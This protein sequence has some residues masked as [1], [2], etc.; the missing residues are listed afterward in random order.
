MA[1][2]QQDSVDFACEAWAYQWVGLFGRDPRKASE[3]LGRLGST[4]GLVRVMQDGAGSSTAVGQQFP[5]GFLG[6]GLLVNCVL[7]HMP[8][9]EREM[10]WRHYVDRWYVVRGMLDAQKKTV[11]YEPV[12]L[13]RP[14]KQGFMA[15]RMGICPAE[16]YRRRDTAKSFIR[17]A[18]AG[19][20][21]VGESKVDARPPGDGVCSAQVR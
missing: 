10:I 14:V 7:K 19:A 16:Y 17:G 5:E 3:Y 21:K 15:D 11:T 4:L 13:A 2:W 12:R 1:R 8:A 20:E 9:A 18:L 6:E